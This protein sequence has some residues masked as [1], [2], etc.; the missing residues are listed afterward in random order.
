M[1]GPK[2]TLRRVLDRENF[3]VEV[4]KALAKERYGRIGEDEEPPDKGDDKELREEV[5]WQETKSS[6]IFDKQDNNISF[7]RARATNM[8]NNKRIHLPKPLLPNQ[9]AVMELRKQEALKVFDACMALLEK[10]EELKDENL[11]DRQRRGL[12][13]LKVKVKEG[14]LVITQTDKSGRFAVFSRDEYIRAG[15]EHTNKDREVTRDYATQNQQLLNGHMEWLTAVLNLGGQWDQQSRCKNNLLNHGL[16]VCPMTLLFKDHKGWTHDLGT[17]PPTRNLVAG[18][19]GQNTGLSELLSTILEPVADQMSQ[20]MEA[21]STT[22]M[23]GSIE[24]LNRGK[25]KEPSTDEDI[26]KVTEEVKPNTGTPTVTVTEEQ[27]KPNTGTPTVTQ[28]T[29]VLDKLGRHMRMREMRG[30]MTDARRRM[31]DREAKDLS[32]VKKGSRSAKTIRGAQLLLASR[33]EPGAAQDK[34]RRTI[35]GADVE[36]LFPSIEDI[37]TANVCFKAVLES[38]VKFTDFNYK[39]GLE[40]VAMHLTKEEVLV[41][42]LRRVLP[43]RIT[44]QGARPG[45]TGPVDGE[46]WF[47][48]DLEL[49]EWEQKLVVASVVQVAVIIMMNS[50]IYSFNGKYYQQASGGPIGLRATCACARV[51]MNTWDKAWSNLMRRNN[52]VVDLGSR[53]MDDIRVFL[54]SLKEGWRWHEGARHDLLY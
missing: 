51:V 46:K 15:E 5:E 41:N 22:D 12:K 28:D 13:S 52:I 4:E 54:G 27:V 17:P 44:N 10:K 47:H 9:E 49:T 39:K 37:E 36:A 25:A 29:P 38:E 6:L 43:T 35:V 34:S 2:F 53:Y 18:N 50:H 3:L 21:K 24:D 7:A 45:V 19:K 48:R 42:P 33:A 40:Y 32:L 20:S 8:K 26:T 14:W 16:A 31:E 23:I 1:L 30:K 11:T